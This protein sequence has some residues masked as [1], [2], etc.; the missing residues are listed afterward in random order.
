MGIGDEIE[1]MFLLEKKC[2]GCGYST[3]PNLRERCEDCGGT[4]FTT[5]EFGDAVLRLVKNE[6]ARTAFRK[7]EC[8][9]E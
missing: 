8:D 3:S 9:G 1:R 5:T 4:G 6:D 7:R 2:F